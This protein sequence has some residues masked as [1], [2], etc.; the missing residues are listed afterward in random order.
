MGQK[1]KNAGKKQSKTCDKLAN[2]KSVKATGCRLKMVQII[3]P[4]IIEK[5]NEADDILNKISKIHYGKRY[6][7]VRPLNLTI[8][9]NYPIEDI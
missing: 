5:Q 6:A 9:S 4:N 7:G 8:T 1:A 3:T 2:A